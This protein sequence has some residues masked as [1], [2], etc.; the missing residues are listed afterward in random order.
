MIDHG[1]LGRKWSIFTFLQH[2][3]PEVTDRD[4]CMTLP[5]HFDNCSVVQ[6]GQFWEAGL[7]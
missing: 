1:D 5:L 6:A 3:D 2:V 4:E 7:L